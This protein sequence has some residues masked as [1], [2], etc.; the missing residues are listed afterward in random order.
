MNENT[1]HSFVQILTWHTFI[2]TLVS[3]HVCSD[4]RL[5]RIRPDCELGTHPN[6]LKSQHTSMQTVDSSHVCS[7]SRLKHIRPDCELGTHPNRLKTR[8]TSMQTVDSSH[9]C[10]DSVTF[11]YHDFGTHVHTV[12]H[13]CQVNV[14]RRTRTSKCGMSFF[15]IAMVL[16]VSPIQLVDFMLITHLYFVSETPFDM[17]TINILTI[18]FLQHFILG[19]LFATHSDYGIDM[20]A[21][22]SILC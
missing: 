17:L 14:F 21:T 3:A 7:D 6:R 11:A 8:H 16:H 20:K 13:T 18:V 9:V 4:S 12:Q 22:D 19:T 5:E 2:Q 15:L 1:A 10:S